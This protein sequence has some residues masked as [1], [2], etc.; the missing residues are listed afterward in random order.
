MVVLGSPNTTQEGVVGHLEVRARPTG[1]AVAAGHR[2]E[3]RG[4]LEVAVSDSSDSILS[5]RP[6]ALRLLACQ[7]SRRG[8][9][10]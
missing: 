3:P 6:A 2:A 7:P 1:E 4:D 5:E 10:M 8:I 9:R